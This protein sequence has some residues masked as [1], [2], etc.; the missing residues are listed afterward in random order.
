V[1]LVIHSGD[2]GKPEVLDALRAIAPVH[3][4]RGNMDRGEWA[5]SLPESEVVEVQDQLLYVIH[6][7]E[8]LEL[9]PAAAGFR[10]VISGHS[11]RPSMD[12]RQGVIYL[13]PGSAGPRRFS[14]PV[15]LGLIRVN[16]VD[17]AVRF[18][19]LARIIHEK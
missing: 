9:D 11:H 6:D 8:R 3:A 16:R 4:V 19:E 15:C 12:E 7:V 17:L 1:D 18:I 14:L 10:A 2:I 13:N 5:R